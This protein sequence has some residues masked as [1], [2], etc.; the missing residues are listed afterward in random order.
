MLLF[1][2]TLINN[3]RGNSVN[4]FVRATQFL[5]AAFLVLLFIVGIAVLVWLV[6]NLSQYLDDRWSEFRGQK[7]ELQFLMSLPVIFAELI[8]G[9][10]FYLNLLLVGQQMFKQSA[11]KWIWALSGSIFGLALSFVGIYRWLDLKTAMPPI[12]G[13]FLVI[14]ILLTLALGFIVVTMLGLLNR[15]TNAIRE[16]EEVI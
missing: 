2:D 10:T 13:I 12:I 4:R 15:A 9:L 5:G 1:V 11:T 16:L 3:S 6:P 14:A 8:L 7:D